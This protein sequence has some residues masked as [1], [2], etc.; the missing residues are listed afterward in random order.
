M[1]SAIDPTKPVDG[2]PAVKL[3]LRN[4]LQAAKTEIEA[5]QVG[6]ADTAH[7][8]LVGDLT[9]VG[10]LATKNVVA[11][12]DI[13][14]GAV[15]TSKLADAAVTTIKLADGAVITAKLPDG[16]VTAP[17]LADAAVTT[18]KLPDGAVTTPKLPDGAVTAPKLADAAV[19]MAKLAD[20]AVTTAKLVD[21]AVTQAKLAT[22]AVGAAQLQDG[23]PINMQDQLLIRPQLK[24]VS[25]TST[26]PAVSAGTLIL[27]LET[28]NVFQVTLT[29]NV[30]IL[31][32]ANPPASGRA[33]ACTLILKQDATGGRTLAWPSSVLWAA[34]MRPLVTP[35]ANAVDIYAFVTRDGGVTWYGFP[36]GQ[37]FS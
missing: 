28:G 17:K 26:T 11:A 5:L 35:A 30:T 21:G 2:V 4:N 36:G 10:A 12:A 15:T 37:G 7:Q 25:E 31:T 33:G 8:H 9:D 20:G 14:A 24:D 29:G 18:A 27:D 13:A 19:T 32:L 6:K 23:I 34:G 1:V 3:N 16:A 22:G